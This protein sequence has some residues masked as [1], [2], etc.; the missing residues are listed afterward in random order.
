[1]ISG[2][3]LAEQIGVAPATLCQ[4]A[5]KGHLCRG[6]DVSAWAVRGPG[7]RVIGYEKPVSVTATLTPPGGRAL[8]G[9]G[10]PGGTPS[11]VTP[12]LLSTAPVRNPSPG[13]DGSADGTAL[14]LPPL[15]TPP[16]RKNPSSDGGS[17]PDGSM[18]PR[19]VHP[20]LPPRVDYFR[21][22][23][24]ASTALVLTEAIRHDNPSARHVISTASVAGCALTGYH[25]GGKEWALGGALMGWFL[26]YQQQRDVS[27]SLAAQPV[28]QRRM[29]VHL[30][31][32]RDP[33]PVETLSA[34]HEG[35]V[36]VVPLPSAHVTSA[37]IWIEGER[38]ARRNGQAS[39]PLQT[40]WAR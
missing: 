38:H 12:T 9:D 32:V 22:A 35:D 1:M 19:E 11:V 27:P 10:R 36:G 25:I 13:G 5:A 6:H 23:A 2:K 28:M 16:A 7:G 39:G 3:S 29:H 40:L 20:V 18:P 24:A 8:S 31:A 30:E 37:P 33:R 17:G 21:P 15:P 34:F 26:A 14:R 4:A